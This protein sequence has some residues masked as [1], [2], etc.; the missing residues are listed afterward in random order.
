MAQRFIEIKN[1]LREFIEQ[2]K[3]FF[4]ATAAAARRFVLEAPILVKILFPN[5]EHELFT[6]IATF[7]YLVHVSHEASE[8]HSLLD[9]TKTPPPGEYRGGLLR[10]PWAIGVRKR[11]GI[12]EVTEFHSLL[13]ILRRARTDRALPTGNYRERRDLCQVI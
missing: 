6:T 5:R 4:V 13:P 3:I 1:S 12:G 8:T 9:E 11:N 7:D 10:E 2:Q